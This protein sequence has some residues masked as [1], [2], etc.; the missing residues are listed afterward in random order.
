MIQQITV[1]QHTL[2]HGRAGKARGQRT[3]WLLRFNYV[4]HHKGKYTI[5]QNVVSPLCV[6]AEHRRF[7]HHHELTL[8]RFIP[9]QMSESSCMR[10][11]AFL[12]GNLM[13]VTL[14]RSQWIHTT[15][16]E[17]CKQTW[18][19]PPVFIRIIGELQMSNLGASF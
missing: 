13:L 6:N 5:M 15:R 1:S 3:R 7:G 12:W 18:C 14:D 17:Y 16:L 10:P 2:P 11:C 4:T 9:S 8:A 19:V